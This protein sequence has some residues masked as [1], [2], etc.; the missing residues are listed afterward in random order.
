MFALLPSRAFSPAA[1]KP[2]LLASLAKKPKGECRSLSQM[3]E[4]RQVFT[5][6]RSSRLWSSER[7]ATG[8]GSEHRPWPPTP[9]AS[10]GASGFQVGE[11]SEVTSSAEVDST[12]G[13]AA[14]VIELP[15]GHPTGAG[16]EHRPLAVTA[17]AITTG[18]RRVPKPATR[19]GPSGRPAVKRPIE[20]AWIGTSA[21]T[22]PPLRLLHPRLSWLSGAL[23]RAG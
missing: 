1:R 8:T 4:S 2:H 7:D 3:E 12:V 22:S 19:G 11:T 21:A 16:S 14:I 20:Q 23:V 17:L 6:C 9:L 18:V 5:A 15:G 13:A 10:P